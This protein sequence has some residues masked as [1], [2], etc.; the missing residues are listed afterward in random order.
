MYQIYFEPAI[1]ILHYIVN[2]SLKVRYILHIENLLKTSINSVMILLFAI[3]KYNYTILYM[4]NVENR[5][6]N[7]KT[8]NTHTS[9]S[10]AP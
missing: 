3:F 7:K 10:M 9:A 4:N 1:N 2:N 5:H 8:V 6:E